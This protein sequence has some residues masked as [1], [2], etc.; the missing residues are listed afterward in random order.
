MMA[1]GP[2]TMA[3]KDLAATELDPNVDDA[4]VEQ[5]RKRTL[6]NVRLR[7]AETKKLILIPTPTSDP[8]DPLNWYAHRSLIPRN[9][10]E[11]WRR[12]FYERA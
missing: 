7:H 3:T 12:Q 9:C 8:N 10:P 1:P 6:G 5:K 2:D 11:F 4:E